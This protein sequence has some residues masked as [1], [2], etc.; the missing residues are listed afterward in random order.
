MST[1]HDDDSNGGASTCSVKYSRLSRGALWKLRFLS[2]SLATI[3]WPRRG[4][5]RKSLRRP[6]TTMSDAGNDVISASTDRPLYHTLHAL[7][8]ARW[9]LTTTKNAW[10]WRGDI[11]AAWFTEALTQNW[12]MLILYILGNKITE[13]VRWICL[14]CKSLYWE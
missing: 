14:E 7:L 6:E 13:K 11:A 1:T 3:T 2:S 5:Y 8:Y 4:R 9:C 10:Y 12:K